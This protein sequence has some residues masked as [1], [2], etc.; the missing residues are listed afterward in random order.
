[1]KEIGLCLVT[2]LVVNIVFG[3][4]VTKNEAKDDEKDENQNKEDVAVSGIYLCYVYDL[5]TLDIF[6]LVF[7]FNANNTYWHN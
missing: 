6:F 2:V 1:M 7:V 4:P 5:H 3:L